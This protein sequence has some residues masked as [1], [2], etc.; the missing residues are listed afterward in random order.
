MN[1]VKNFVFCAFVFLWPIHIRFLYTY[2][3]FG[4]EILQDSRHISYESIQFI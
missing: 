3:E 4:F 2:N 1:S